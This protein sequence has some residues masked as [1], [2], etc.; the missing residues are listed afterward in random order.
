MTIFGLQSRL[1]AKL[2]MEL[3][4]QALQL[5]PYCEQRVKRMI[6]IGVERMVISKVAEMP[7]K[8]NLAI[9]N[10]KCLVEYLSEHAKAYGSYPEIEE[11]AFDI[12]I[13][14]CYPL[15]PYC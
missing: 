15:W 13:A 5:S 4:C 8:I 14:E 10:I 6:N 3:E 1:L 12:A 2:E 11:I 9:K 7:D